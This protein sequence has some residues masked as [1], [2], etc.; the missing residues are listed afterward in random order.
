MGTQDPLTGEV[1]T[2]AVGRRPQSSPHDFP[3]ERLESPQDV[4]APF[5]KSRGLRERARRKP[6]CR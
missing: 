4:A 6:G 2:V 5:S 1:T 3:V